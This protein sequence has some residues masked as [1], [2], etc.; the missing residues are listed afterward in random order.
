MQAS[1]ISFVA[2]AAALAQPAPIQERLQGFVDRQQVAGVTAVYTCNGKTFGPLA[3]GFQDAPQKKAMRPDSLFQIMSMTKPV[4][5]LGILMLAEEGKLSVNDPLERH[6]PQFKNVNPKG[7]APTLRD[8][9]THTSGII[10]NPPESSMPGF[11][12]KL[13]KSLAEAVDLYAQKQVEFEPGSK[14]MYSNPGIAILGRVIEVASGQSYE[15]FLAARIFTPLGM[16]DTHFFV[17]ASKHDRV[18]LVHESRAGKLQY[19]PATILGGD[20]REFRKGAKYPAP[21]FGL[22][23]TA[24]DLNTLYQALLNGKLLSKPAREVMATPHTAG[25]Q[26]GWHTGTGFGL[27]WEV[28]NQ[29]AGQLVFHSPGTYLHG[30]AFG[31]YGWIDPVKKLTGVF[32]VQSTGGGSNQARDAFIQM[33]SASCEY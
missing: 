4:T 31:T 10:G 13:D 18:A 25:I 5:A 21:E 17:P 9:L 12:Q 8:L 30:G 28:V 3:V 19:A 7:K 27:G 2:A 29:P 20:S 32:L 6:L 23:S 26:A 16:K 33:A 22:Y 11:Y 15:Q 14:W 24:T 1:W